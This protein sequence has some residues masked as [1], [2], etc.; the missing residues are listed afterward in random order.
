M[1]KRI[2]CTLCHM[3]AELYTGRLLPPVCYLSNFSALN[4]S[5]SS[6]AFESDVKSV[7]HT[8]DIFQPRNGKRV[9][10][11]NAGHID[12]KRPRRLANFIEVKT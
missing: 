4:L 6:T 2:E 9:S 5:H 8:S 1:D 3:F 12:Q 11:E 7:T 10:P